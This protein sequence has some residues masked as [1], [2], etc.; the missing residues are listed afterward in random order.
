MLYLV[1]PHRAMKWIDF[2]GSI[3][4]DLAKQLGVDLGSLEWRDDVD[5]VADDDVVRVALRYGVPTGQG[6]VVNAGHVVQ[7]RRPGELRDLFAGSIGVMAGLKK[8][9]R[10]SDTLMEA[11]IPG[12]KE[13]SERLDREVEA[14]L[15]ESLR[16]ADVDAAN[17]I[18]KREPN[19]SVVAHWRSLGGVLP[20]PL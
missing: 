5:W 1:S 6:V 19:E 8:Q 11:M 16:E 18:S 14:S 12:W 13:S 10:G 3:V 15:V 4:L 20:D 17:E 7:V 2:P 9:L